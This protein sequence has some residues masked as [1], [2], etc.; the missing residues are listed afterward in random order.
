MPYHV[1]IVSSKGAVLV[2]ADKNERWIEEH[3]AAP[4]RNG[5]D[6]LFDGAVLAWAN[7][8]TIH[9]VHSDESFKEWRNDP[10]ND[11]GFLTR[12]ELKEA[13]VDIGDD[14]TYQFITGPP[15]RQHV[16]G[17]HVADSLLGAAVEVDTASTADPK[18]V[19]VIYGRDQEANLALFSWLRTVG[20]EPREWDQLTMSTGNGSPYIGQ[21]LDRA[22]RQ[23]QAVVAFF[24]P[25]ERVHGRAS[26]G[27]IGDWRLQSRPNVLIEAGMAV[28]A[29]PD[30]TIFVILGEL[31]LPSDLAG[32]SYVRLDGT[33]GPLN[34]LATRLEVA[35]CPIDRSGMHWMDASRFPKRHGISAAP[36]ETA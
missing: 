13:F 31:D 32:R 22:F 7:V 27:R 26:L 15:G 29:H 28:M 9:V 35:G 5:A 33:P 21:I 17:H 6:I 34:A 19:M 2:E 16:S 10:G 36:A 25:D 1:K 8:K 18:S 12:D 30:R 3:I 4:R 20:L 11:D 24:T 23:V 14:V